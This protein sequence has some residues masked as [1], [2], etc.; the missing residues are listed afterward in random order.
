MSKQGDFTF[1]PEKNMVFYL[2]DMYQVINTQTPELWNTLKNFQEESFMLSSEKWITDLATKC[3]EGH[4]G[5]SFYIC[6]R[7][8][9]YIAKHDWNKYV[10]EISSSYNIQ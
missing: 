6:L 2:Q 8:M 4:S 3:N 5:A 1:I 9:E 10:T 7:N